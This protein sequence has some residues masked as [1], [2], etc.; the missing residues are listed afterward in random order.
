MAM[1][2]EHFAWVTSIRGTNAVSVAIVAVR[3]FGQ[4]RSVAAWS[5]RTRDPIKENAARACPATVVWMAGGDEKSARGA[6]IDAAFGQRRQLLVGRLFLV[7]RLLQQ[8][9]AI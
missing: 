2:R 1:S 9:G 7:E 5:I 6:K 4:G 3:H 8:A